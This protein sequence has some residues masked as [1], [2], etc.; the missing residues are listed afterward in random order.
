MIMKR[1][2]IIIVVAAVALIGAGLAFAQMGG[3]WGPGVGCNCRNGYNGANG[4]VNLENLKKFQKETLSMRDE[5]IANRA[6]L[7]NEY[8]KPAPDETRIADLQKQ[9]IDTRTKIQKTG[10][11]YGL[12]AQQQGYGRGMGRGMTAVSGNGCPRWQ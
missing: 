10:E 12:P 1:T 11:K 3:G 7:A 5:L 9:M 8:A 2:V 6:E 4:T